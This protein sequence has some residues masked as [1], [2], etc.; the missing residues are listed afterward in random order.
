MPHA[1][2][3]AGALRKWGLSTQTQEAFWVIAYDAAM[4]IRTIV[5]I[6]RG[7]YATVGVHLPSV[8][9]AVLAIGCD[10]FQVAHNHPTGDITP[11]M[12][13]IQ[14]T[15]AIMQG[16]NHLGLYFED[17]HIVGPGGQHFSFAANKMLVP[18]PYTGE[19]S[20]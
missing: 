14:T 2:T 5:E 4:N 8:F 19:L 13:D 10:R 11:T 12:K 3:M 1:T 18:A 20:A 15:Q 7:T 9:S 16:A 6:G 17:H